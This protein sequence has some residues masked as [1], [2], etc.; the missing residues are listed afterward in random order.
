[1]SSTNYAMDA[2]TGELN[3]DQLSG[4]NYD[5]GPGLIF[6]QQ[7]NVPSAPTFTNPSSYYDKLLLVLDDGG[8]P[9][10]AKF[11]IAISPDDWVTTLYVQSDNTVG[12]SLGSEDYQTYANWGGASGELV[13]GLLSNTIYKVKVKAMQG[14]FTETGYGPEASAATVSPTLSFD[15][16]VS[17]SD[18]DTE[19]PFLVSFGNLIAGSVVD[20]PEKIWV[21]FSTN[22]AS[23]GKVYVSSGNAGL[24]SVR[25]GASIPSATADLSVATSGYG[26]QG[27]SVS[28]G[29]GGP[30]V[31]VSP[32]DNS[33]DNVGL[34]DTSLREIFAS[35]API[36]SGRSS[37]LLKAK[38]SP[39]TPAASDYADLL[40]VVV[41]A[42]F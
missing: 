42:S 32:Y 39:I 30:L 40:T 10:D 17:S 21:D 20:S 5:M 33:G 11:A 16:D 36:T 4:T 28:E 6:T 3:D 2:I 23:G 38:S 18:T 15:I 25:S 8:N 12:A 26:A 19:P 35:S 7:A 24:S 22:G 13:I 9:T 1:M 27:S 31:F 14:K 37:F 34:L 29:S 41:S